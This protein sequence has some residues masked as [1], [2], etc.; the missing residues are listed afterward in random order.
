L[1]DLQRALADPDPPQQ[2]AAALALSQSPAAEAAE[3]LAQRPEL[4]ARI[5]AGTLSWSDLATRLG[6]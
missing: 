4:A 2:E 1:E 3:L 5:R 6:A